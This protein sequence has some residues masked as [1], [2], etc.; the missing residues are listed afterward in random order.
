MNANYIVKL[1]F[2][3]L[4]LINNT[5]FNSLGE[6]IFDV[7]LQ[8]NLVSK[9]FKITKEAGGPGIPIVKTSI[10][11]VTSNT[12]KIHF[13]WAGRGTTFTVFKFISV[14]LTV[15]CLILL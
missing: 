15:E 4:I 3:E 11:N 8:D 9:D 5:S 2:A 1:H 12:L 13:Y 10:V 14:L 7:Y 6:R